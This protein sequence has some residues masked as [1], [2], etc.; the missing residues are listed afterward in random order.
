MSTPSYPTAGDGIIGQ[1]TGTTLANKSCFPGWA[2][3]PIP[4]EIAADLPSRT[5][6]AAKE[7]LARAIS[8]C[9]RRRPGFVFSDFDEE[10]LQGLAAD[11]HA[12]IDQ[13]AVHSNMA[14]Q[15]NDNERSFDKFFGIVRHDSPD[16][17]AIGIVWGLIA[18]LHEV[19][20]PHALIS[21]ELTALMAGFYRLAEAFL[22]AVT[23]KRTFVANTNDAPASNDAAIGRWRNGHLTFVALTGGLILAHVRAISAI[24]SRNDAEAIAALR[25]AS[26]LF[27]ASAAAMHLTGD[28]TPEDYEGI[29]ALM[30]PPPRPRRLFGFV[31]RRSSTSHECDKKTGNAA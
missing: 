5:S 3:F 19:N 2:A 31:Q 7:I 16:A 15:L 30:N 25:D 28:L 4:S 8:L 9:E 22:P 26:C 27:A 20:R 13:Y 29:R 12:L 21:A 11:C 18:M 10:K 17:F 24:E 6:P 14:E 23:G 1:T